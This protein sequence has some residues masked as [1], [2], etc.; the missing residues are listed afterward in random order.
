[1]RA[2]AATAKS[3]AGKPGLVARIKQALGISP[4]PCGVVHHFEDI[5]SLS[6]AQPAVRTHERV[7]LPMVSY[8]K[9][10]GTW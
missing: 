9:L 3:S 10:T 8:N 5:R 4:A 7:E 2:P 1:M 6:N